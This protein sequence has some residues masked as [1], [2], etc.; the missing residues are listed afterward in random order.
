[1]L[2]VRSPGANGTNRIVVKRGSG[3]K[4]IS[5]AEVGVKQLGHVLVLEDERLHLREAFWTAYTVQINNEMLEPQPILPKSESYER[6]L[7]C[8]VADSPVV[9]C[10]PSQPPNAV[11]EPKDEAML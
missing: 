8:C 11:S 4:S 7:H 2:Q 10:Q 1:V 3:Y 5:V 9:L 6:R